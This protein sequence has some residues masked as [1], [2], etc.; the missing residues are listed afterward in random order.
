MVIGVPKETAG[1][2]TRVAQTPETVAKLK[3]QGFD[4]IVECGA[5][6]NSYFPDDAYEQA[7]ASLGTADQ[8]LGADFVTK[9]AAPT[10]AELVKMKNGAGLISFLRP[11]DDL[12]TI[13]ELAA[14]GIT[15]YAME[16]VPRSTKAQ[17]MDALSAMA[18]I[19]GYKAVLLAAEVLPRFFPLLTT[20]AGTIKPASVLVLGAGV[21]GLQALATARRLGAVTS[22]YDVRAAA[23]EEAKS[24]GAKFIELDL[25]TTDAAAS[26]GYA[27]ALSS[28]R[29]ERQVQLLAGHISKMDVVIT[30]A[31]IPGRKA[32]LLISEEAVKGMIPGSVIVDIAAPNGGNCALT[33]PGETVIRHGVTIIGS[34]NLPAGMPFHASQLYA[35]T[36]LA[37]VGELVKDGAFRLDL[38]DEIIKG[39]CITHNG[40]VVHDRVKS[41]L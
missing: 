5:G 31:L 20:A 22:A 2:E 19:A 35:R 4:V 18:S 29:A 27:A 17:K 33:V 39:C 7:G 28:D 6:A 25:D 3:K 1:G 15:A 26:G 8:A 36:V 12:E 38:E 24:L 21:A 11:L 41:L 9:V 23:A 40:Q 32:P 14:K 34:M 13:R 16:L 37:G 10:I 30:T